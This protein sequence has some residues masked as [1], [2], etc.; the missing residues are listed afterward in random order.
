MEVALPHVW[1]AAADVRT[2]WRSAFW[3]LSFAF[4]TRSRRAKRRVDFDRFYELRYEDLIR[5]PVGQMGAL[6]D[7]LGLGGFEKL[8]PQLQKY[9]ADLEGYETNHYQLSD[10]QAAKINEKWGDVIRA[11]GYEPPSQFKP[12][13]SNVADG[14]VPAES[15]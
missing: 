6:Y 10:E 5:D 11:Y 2:A 4:T 3:T 8:L 9:L 12:A 15:N 14:R 7:H 13:A 1:P